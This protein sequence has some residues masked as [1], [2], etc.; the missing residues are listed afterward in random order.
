MSNNKYWQS[1]GE[2]NNSE[3]YQKAAKDEFT[4]ELPFEAEDGKSFY[5]LLLQ[6]EIFLNI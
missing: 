6:E 5:M 2:L 4:E 1:F 3:A